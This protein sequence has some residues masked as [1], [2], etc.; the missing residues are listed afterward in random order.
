MPTLTGQ[1]PASSFP[2]LSATW[3]VEPYADAGAQPT[4]RDVE[5]ADWMREM[6]W[7]GSIAGSGFEDPFGQLLEETVRC[8]LVY[9]HAAREL[10]WGTDRRGRQIIRKL[11]ARHPKATLRFNVDESYALASMEQYVQ[12]SDGFQRRII[13][14]EKLM[15]WT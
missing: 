8:G 3:S 6:L 4:G 13:P 5:N 11:A 9:G 2:L 10:V 7:D 1:L 12:T 15:L 14:A